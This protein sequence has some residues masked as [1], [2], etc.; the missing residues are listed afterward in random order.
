MTTPPDTGSTGEEVFDTNGLPALLA[1][2]FRGPRLL[3]L[4][5]QRP[6][7]SRGQLQVK[8][9]IDTPQ[10]AT[11]YQHGGIL[12]FVLRQMLAERAAV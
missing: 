8:V 10:E 1:A 2:D 7:G 11:Y 12:L 6:D 5:Y 9:R 4:A 3:S